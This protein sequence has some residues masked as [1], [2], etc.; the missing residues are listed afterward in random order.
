METITPAVPLNALGGTGAGHA[1][2]ADK[3]FD[4]LL[5]AW[6]IEGLAARFNLASLV[7]EHANFDLLV[8]WDP[9]MLFLEGFLVLVL[10]AP[11]QNSLTSQTSQGSGAYQDFV[12]ACK[13]S[14][15]SVTEV[16]VGFTLAV[17]LLAFDV[18]LSL[19]EDDPTDS[20]GYGV[21]ILVISTFV[22]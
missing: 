2:A 15:L 18:F 12:A 4:G 3:P 11:F 13:S 19:S 16:A 21:L 14:G 9:A 20:L 1:L 5:P 17:G 8:A 6:A 22:L 10:A 7:T